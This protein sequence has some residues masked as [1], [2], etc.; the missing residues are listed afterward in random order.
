MKNIQAI[1]LGNVV[2]ISINGKLSKKCCKDSKEADDL[3]KLVLIAKENPTDENMIKIRMFLNER[4]RSLLYVDWKELETDVETG[5]IYL[6][7]FNTPIPDTLA[8]VIKEYHEKKYPMNPILNFWKLLML[9]P[10]IRVRNSLFD[11]I[12]THDFVLTDTGYMVVYKSV[13]PVKEDKIDNGLPEFVSKQY[14][15]VKKD[16]KCS[17]NKYVVYTTTDNHDCE[18]HAYG[19]TKL[20]TAETWNEKEKGVEIIGKLGDLFDTI[21]DGN[22][23]NEVPVFTDMHTRTF[24]IKIGEPVCMERKECDGDPAV[25]CS[26]GLHVGATKYVEKFANSN[27]TILVCFVN[28]AN[29]VAVPNYDHSKMRVTEYFPYA[30]ADYSDGKIDIV[31]EMYFENDYMTYEIQ[32]LENQIASIKA[33]ESPIQKAINADAEDR[34]MDELMKI[35]EG[36]MIDILNA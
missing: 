13:Y 21:F 9:N 5:K 3:F 1:K 29:V 17:P 6:A 8:D 16:W 11:F 31:E 35:I 7:G 4:T 15:H 36:R 14:L 2:N 24:R 23:E 30:I 22:E 12:T 26:Y 18:L 27:S 10:D 32:E 34:P 28:P 33:N 25:E 20:E 19:I